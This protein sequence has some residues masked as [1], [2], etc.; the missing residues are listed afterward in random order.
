MTLDEYI[1]AIRSGGLSRYEKRLVD[2]CR[3]SIEITGEI[4]AERKIG[5]GESKIGGSPD[6]PP[7][8]K[9]PRSENEPL[10]FVAQFKMSDTAVYDADYVLP[11]T[12]MMYFFYDAEDGTWGYDPNDAGH[13]SVIYYNGDS[14]RLKRRRTPSAI[15]D[16]GKFKACRV[17]FSQ[18][19]SLPPWESY[20]VKKLDMS[21]QEMSS[22]QDILLPLDEYREMHTTHRLLGHPDVLQNDMQLECQYVTNGIYCGDDSYLRDPRA[23]SL[24][25]GAA[26]WRLLLQIDTDEDM[27]MMWDDSGRLYFWIPKDALESRD[28]DKT[29]VML[30]SY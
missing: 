22:Y 9:W 23:A 13:W 15:S 19:V 25:A 14:S 24:E 28:F 16:E 20:D 27:E 3:S 17:S 1:S 29:W 5:I 26:D 12:G 10:S 2:L 6:L 8:I 7:E 30:Q 4:V 11:P 21:K 18:G